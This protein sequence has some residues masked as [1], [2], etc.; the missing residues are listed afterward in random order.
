MKAIK[1]F[2]VT[3][4]LSTLTFAL[5][6]V[7]SPARAT[8]EKIVA[9]LAQVSNYP[10]GAPPW[11]KAPV[12][13]RVAAL[14]SGEVVVESIVN[15]VPKSLQKTIAKENFVEIQRLASLLSQAQIKEEKATIVCGLVMPATRRVLR[16]GV[17]VNASWGGDVKTVAMENSCVYATQLIFMSAADEMRATALSAKLET[18]AHEFLQP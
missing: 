5:S 16:V 17:P 12:Y 4:L 13:T 3:A 10:Q 14:S 11:A 1:K 7:L 18:F 9:E 15:G 6:A 2:A 8:G